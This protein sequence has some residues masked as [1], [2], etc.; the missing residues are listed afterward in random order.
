MLRH[1]RDHQS[2]IGRW[3][4][5]VDRYSFV[6][7]MLLMALGAMLVTASSPPVAERIG[8]PPFYFVKNQYLF[9]LL[10]LPVIVGISLFS[11]R[12]IRRMALAGLLGSFFLMLLVPFFG[13][14]TKGASRWIN[15]FGLSLQPSEFMKPCFAVVT[16]WIFAL[17][18]KYVDFPAYKISIAV[19][20]TA[21]G[22]LALQPDFGMI[23]A[24]TIIWGG[25][26]FL[27]GLPMIL[28]L[29]MAVLAIGG[30]VGAYFVFDH[31]KSR[32]DRFLDPQSGD[33]YQVERSL[34]A[35]QNGGFLG[36]GPG[37]GQVKLSLPDSHTDFIYAV[38]GEEL[39]IIF[40]LLIAGLFFTI[41][42]KGMVRIRR[43]G[44]V[45]LMIAVTG[46]LIQFSIQALINMGVS[47]Q[48]FPAK[49]MT[50][51]FLSYGGSSIIAVAL[52]M[53]MLLALTRKRFGKE[54]F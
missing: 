45:F 50:L 39:G 4:W 20:L 33:N 30:G 7:I 31:V 27:A 15:I 53:G 18:Q 37:E 34:E 14:E 26:I 6:A 51:P 17:R 44:D 49:G 24:T 11:P 47:V 21:V 23:V 12:N 13:F 10:A 3:W 16:A 36:K 8:L 32:I 5:T 48:L 52:A 1:S 29:L 54:G 40:C 42:A 41:A 25:Q 46:L 38:A 28:V 43:E 9:L 2:L 22:L 19:Y 35:F